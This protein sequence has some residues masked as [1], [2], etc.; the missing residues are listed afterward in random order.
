M[1]DLT[2]KI[3]FYF[4]CAFGNLILE[5]FRLYGNCFIIINLAVCGIVYTN[6]IWGEPEQAPHKRFVNACNICMVIHLSSAHRLIVSTYWA[7]C[8]VLC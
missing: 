3:L 4:F 8:N 5:N 2:T 1:R 7:A 6:N